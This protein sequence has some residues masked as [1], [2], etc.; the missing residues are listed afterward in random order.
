[1]AN[2]NFWD[3]KRIYGIK[4][5]LIENIKDILSAAIND[6][7]FYTLKNA[8]DM[9]HVDGGTIAD[10]VREVGLIDDNYG[11][12][13]RIDKPLT[14]DLIEE[15]IDGYCVDS[16]LTLR[17]QLLKEIVTPV[18]EKIEDIAGSIG[19]KSL[20]EDFIVTINDPNYGDSFK[21]VVKHIANNVCK[22]GGVEIYVVPVD[23]SI[24]KEELKFPDTAIAT[25]KEFKGLVD[26]AAKFK[27]ENIKYKWFAESNDGSFKDESRKSF[28][29]KKEC[30]NDMRNAALEK[31]KWNTEFDEDFDYMDDEDY[32]EYRVKFSKDKIIHESYS[33]IYTYEIGRVY[34]E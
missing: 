11:I 30:Y 2:Y 9:A 5:D 28:A 33:G 27:D 1:M 18:Y 25:I 12:R 31:M 19:I 29:T 15:T 10:D 21:A 24:S 23:E 3:A 4:I 32:I 6:G 13:V 8:I 26:F 17:N 7:E 16:L 20:P 22:D 34:E 14:G